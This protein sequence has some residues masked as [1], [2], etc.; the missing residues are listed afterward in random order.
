MCD[1]LPWEESELRAAFAACD[2]SGTGTISADEL[3]AVMYALGQR[4][5]ASE[6]E[7]IVREA[8]GDEGDRIGF[9]DFVTFL[10]TT[11]M[12]RVFDRD[13][14]GFIT[15]TELSDGMT[16]LGEAMTDEQVDDMI[17]EADADGDGQIDYR[18]FLRVMAASPR[19]AALAASPRS[20]GN[21]TP[22]QCPFSPP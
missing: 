22:G 11:L 14:D 18:E 17:R 2:D 5:S 6:L 20:A 13:G 12:F 16:T 7:H 19:L 3:G 4:P 9:A 21:L 10:S 8:G 15:A 1:N